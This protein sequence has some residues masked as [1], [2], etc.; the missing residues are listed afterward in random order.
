MM[1]FMSCEGNE[2]GN[3]LQTTELAEEDEK[4]SWEERLLGKR[5]LILGKMKKI[6]PDVLSPF[7]SISFACM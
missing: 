4:S 7:I 6:L 2:Y 1:T 5:L 3:E